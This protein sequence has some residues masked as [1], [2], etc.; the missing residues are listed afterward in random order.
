MATNFLLSSLI[1][2]I[3]Q[4]WLFLSKINIL[5]F[6]FP[7]IDKNEQVAIIIIYA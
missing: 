2:V 3:P 4:G 1:K 7:Y 5:L 6:F